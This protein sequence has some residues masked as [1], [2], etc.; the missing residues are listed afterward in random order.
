MNLQC[1][2]RD[3]DH[4]LLLQIETDAALAAVDP[5]AL[6]DEY[7]LLFLS[8]QMSP[9]MH[10]VLLDRLTAMTGEDYGSVLGR[11]RVQHLLYLII[12]SPEYSIQK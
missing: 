11:E 3:P 12:S 7:N 9:F 5:E 2:M 6:I 4:A 8:G 10:E 1:W